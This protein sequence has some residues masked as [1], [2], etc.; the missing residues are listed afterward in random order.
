[1]ER[2]E[3]TI[4][5]VEAEGLDRYRPLLVGIEMGFFLIGSMFWMD[6]L[7]GANNFKQATWGDLLYSYPAAL[8]AGINMG[9]SAALVLALLK[10]I[11]VRGVVIGATVQTGHFAIISYSMLATNG[12]PG[13]GLYA[14]AFLGLH[15]W[16]LWESFRYARK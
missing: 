10:P 3:Q 12:D 5:I 13:A 15:A 9:C 2:S 6:A 4:R 8:W 1:M 16:M 11:W 7:N 14:L